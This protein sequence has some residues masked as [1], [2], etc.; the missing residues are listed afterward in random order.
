MKSNE[1]NRIPLAESLIV[2]TSF[3]CYDFAFQ[4]WS[5]SD[6]QRNGCGS[7]PT[8]EGGGNRRKCTRLLETTSWY[9]EFEEQIICPVADLE[10]KCLILHRQGKRIAK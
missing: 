9:E 7:V 8:S 1:I 4:R 6:P 10:K 2:S 3:P 5:Q